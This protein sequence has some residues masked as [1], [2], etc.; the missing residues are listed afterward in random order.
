MLKKIWMD[1]GG[2]I[3]SAEIALIGTILVIGMVVGLAS[4]ADAV[5]NELADVGQAVT[6]LNQSYSA[7]GI[8]GHRSATSSSTFTDA[9]DFCDT[10]ANTGVSTRCVT[11]AGTA[12]RY[13]SDQVVHN[14]QITGCTSVHPVFFALTTNGRA[15]LLPSRCPVVIW[16]WDR[17]PACRFHRDRLEA[18]PTC[19]N[20]GPN[21]ASRTLVLCYALILG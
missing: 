8:V 10:T 14:A 21:T 7:N 13:R 3:L 5:T 15:R 2:A 17:L 1:E 4:L 19:T 18:Y 20:A 16:P 12:T 11:F 6:S 9:L